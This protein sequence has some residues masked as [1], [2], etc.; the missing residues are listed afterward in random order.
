MNIDA[1]CRLGLS[2][3][4]IT[5]CRYKPMP[6]LRR[7]D[8][9]KPLPQDL[10]GLLFVGKCDCCD[11][12]SMFLRAEPSKVQLS[13]EVRSNVEQSRQSK[14]E[15]SAVRFSGVPPSV[16]KHSIAKRSKHSKAQRTE[17]KRIRAQ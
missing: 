12:Q 11:L 3:I 1:K 4:C 5:G 2:Y 9:A 8:M 10:D 14:L 16:G 15:L 6:N 7:D 13:A 17:A